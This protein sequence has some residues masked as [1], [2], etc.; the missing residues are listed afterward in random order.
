MGHS[1]HSLALRVS[2]LI[3]KIDKTATAKLIQDIADSSLEKSNIIELLFI[4]NQNTSNNNLLGYH[5]GLMIAK[6]Y[7]S[8]IMIKY[9]KLLHDI[10]DNPRYAQE[11]LAILLLQVSN[12][13]HLGMAIAIHQNNKEVI[14]LYLQLLKKLI[15]QHISPETI[16]EL[17]L[18][19]YKETKSSF[20]NYLFGK[21]NEETCQLYFDYLLHSLGCKPAFMMPLII[22]ELMLQDVNGCTIGIRAADARAKITQKYLLFVNQLLDLG[23]DPEA[24]CTIFEKVTY[25]HRMKFN[26]CLFTVNSQKL[27]FDLLRKLTL[28]GEITVARIVALLHLNGR[29]FIRPENFNDSYSSLM[30]ELLRQGLEVDLVPSIMGLESSTVI[31][32][33][34]FLRHPDNAH[35]LI[36]WAN[37]GLVAWSKEQRDFLYDY[38]SALPNEQKIPLMK[39]ILDRNSN[40][41]CYLTEKLDLEQLKEFRHDIK[42]QLK[43]AVL[44]EAA[45]IA[46]QYRITVEPQPIAL[47]VQPNYSP[48]LFYQAPTIAHSDIQAALNQQPSYYHY[49]SFFNPSDLTAGVNR[50]LPLPQ[51]EINHDD[52]PAAL[53]SVDELLFDHP[54]RSF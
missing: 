24:I 16:H 6:H 54:A 4:Q 32:N 13:I 28:S 3:D 52:A 37:T 48:M 11:V 45:K 26:Q 17:L 21:G 8:E 30:T 20:A 5:L 49:P 38:I 40:L 39:N 42:S 46:E 18:I 50:F 35:E 36:L 43:A 29:S 15:G 25:K 10:T 19:T 47:D 51:T 12:R 34:Y 9:L 7:P 44:A 23:A 1:R 41:S 53:P 27:Y 14:D 2:E 31:S 33:K 22:K